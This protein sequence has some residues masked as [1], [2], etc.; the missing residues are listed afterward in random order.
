MIGD[1]VNTVSLLSTI[2]DGISKKTGIQRSA[3]H[4]I[5]NIAFNEEDVYNEYN[6]QLESISNKASRTVAQFPVIMTYGDGTLSS[7]SRESLTKIYIGINKFIECE[8]ARFLVQAAG[9]NPIVDTKNKTIGQKLDE[10]TGYGYTLESIDPVNAKQIVDNTRSSYEDVSEYVWLNKSGEYL[11]DKL[12]SFEAFNGSGT[13]GNRMFGKVIQR[14][15]VD[16]S[17]PHYTVHSIEFRD[18]DYIT[19]YSPKGNGNNNQNAGGYTYNDVDD[20][21]RP[22][23]IVQTGGSQHFKDYIDNTFKSSSNST[24]QN[25]VDSN[26]YSYDFGGKK[27]YNLTNSDIAGIEASINRNDPTMV[28]I[29]FVL[30]NTGSMREHTIH[31][32]V[33]SSPYWVSSAEM[34][35]FI[36]ECAFRAIGGGFVTKFMSTFLRWKSK[37]IKFFKNLVLDLET[38]DK[39]MR[40][41][42]SNYN[43]S[44]FKKLYNKKSF[45]KLTAL[46]RAIPGMK[47]FVSGRASTMPMTSIV[48]STSEISD[49]CTSLWKNVLKNPKPIHEVISKMSLLSFTVVDVD[50]ELTYTFF[51]GIKDPYVN[52]FGTL[53]TFLNEGKNKEIDII[54]ELINFQKIQQRRM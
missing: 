36:R 24:N 13:G 20:N 1:I 7:E 11:D 5:G 28:P 4:K 51:D 30:D 22:I 38:I 43:N 29:R 40:D 12:A 31:V 33:K 34:K 15:S 49:A 27:T 6:R 10:L 48:C 8:C 26:P 19:Y 53:K 41:S 21:G 46:V 47:K 3:N 37:D 42:K 17:D 39:N 16:D 2:S 35:E 23:H 50:A 14:T 44:I 45:S 52:T 32:N 25:G 54:K 9:L 18:G